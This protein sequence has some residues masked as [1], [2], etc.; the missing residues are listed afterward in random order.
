[1]GKTLKVS[2]DDWPLK[3]S[4]PMIQGDKVD[5]GFEERVP[6]GE[7]CVANMSIP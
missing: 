1:M 5:D 6:L 3:E 2:C 4:I 7:S